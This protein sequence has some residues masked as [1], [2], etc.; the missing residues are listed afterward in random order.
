MIPQEVL[1]EAARKRKLQPSRLAA[2]L[3]ASGR[4]S[5]ADVMC[6][7]ERHVLARVY[8]PNGRRLLARPEFTMLAGE[9]FSDV[10]PDD[11]S[12]VIFVPW[13]Y[14]LDQDQDQIYFRCSCHTYTARIGD[15]ASQLDRL[16]W[17]DRWLIVGISSPPGKH[18]MERW[19]QARDRPSC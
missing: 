11:L 18:D 12:E 1:R 15:L 8:L 5:R 6:A 17:N 13:L 7:H 3:L 4:P 19:R 10:T 2:Q 9:L 16:P 14:D